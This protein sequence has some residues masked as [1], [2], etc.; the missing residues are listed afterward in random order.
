MSE[1]QPSTGPIAQKLA[2]IQLDGHH[3][4]VAQQPSVQLSKKISWVGI[5]DK[6]LWD[7][8]NLIAIL[9]V[10]L[11]IGVFT[12]SLTIQQNELSQTQHDDSEKIAADQQKEDVLVNYQ[13]DISDLLLNFKLGSSVEGNPVRMVAHAKTL[14]ALRQLDPL[15]KGFLIQF[16]YEAQLITGQFPIIS[17][18]DADL[19]GVSLGSGIGLPSPYSLPGEYRSNHCHLQYINLDNADLKDAYLRNADLSNAFLK[20][21]YLGSA[22][23]SG[24]DLSGADLSAANFKGAQVAVEQLYSAASLKLATMPDGST[25]IG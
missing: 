22:D 19:S 4:P 11:M 25:Y 3:L 6:T 9:L 7:W 18:G 13:K 14:T 24:A 2:E 8:L 1:Q 15:Q 17:L 20:G 5:S 23:L 16:L 10:P 12:V 21:A